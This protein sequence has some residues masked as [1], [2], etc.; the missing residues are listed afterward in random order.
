MADVKFSELTAFA[1]ATVDAS[2]VLAIVDTSASTSKKLSID[3][4]FGAVPVNI[5]VADATDSGSIS[6]GSIQTAGGIGVTK[7]LSVGTTSTFTGNILPAASGTVDIGSASAE[8][9][10][11]FFSTGSVLNFADGQEVTVTA[12]TTGLTINAAKKIM[13]RDSAL[14]IS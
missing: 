1:A 12:A 8:I 11:M 4:L 2:D 10:D 13:F 9:N 7:A 3:N 14:S 6:T 5:A